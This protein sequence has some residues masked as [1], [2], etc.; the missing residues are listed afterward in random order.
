MDGP[1]LK[2]ALADK[3]K[4]FTF[5]LVFPFSLSLSLRLFDIA[6]GMMADFYFDVFHNGRVGRLA[7]FAS[8][9]KGFGFGASHCLN[10]IFDEGDAANPDRLDRVFALQT[11]RHPCFIYT[12]SH[13][14]LDGKTIRMLI[15][16]FL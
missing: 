11:A 6:A 5:S 8:C 4:D 2:E 1:L 14:F 13:L 12:L 15:N 10:S 9:E 16:P 7:G 3:V